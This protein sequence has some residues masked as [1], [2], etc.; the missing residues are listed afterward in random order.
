MESNLVDYKK[1]FK[2][3][4]SIVLKSLINLDIEEKKIINDNDD[5]FNL[6]VFPLKKT[7][8]NTIILKIK[9]HGLISL[10]LLLNS[11]KNEKEKINCEFLSNI[12]TNILKKIENIINEKGGEIINFS[13]NEITIIF[14]FSEA[15]E[16]LEKYTFYYSQL[17][18]LSIIEIYQKINLEVLKGIKLDLSFGVSIGQFSIIFLGGINKKINFLFFGEAIEKANEC[19]NFSNE[20]EIIISKNYNEILT[21]LNLIHS[22]CLYSKG[23]KNLFQIDE[24]EEEEE[25]NNFSSYQHLKKLNL[26]NLNQENIENLTSKIKIISSLFPNNIIEYINLNYENLLSEIYPITIMTMTLIL[27]D[28]NDEKKL[29]LII[30]TIQKIIFLTSGKIFLINKIKEG[31]LIKILFGLNFCSLNDTSNSISSSFLIINSLKKYNIKIA[32]GISSGDNYIGLIN[33]NNYNIIGYKIYLSKKLNEEAIKNLNKN[34][35]ENYILIDKETMKLSQK[36]YRSIYLG[37]IILK[38]NLIENEENENISSNVK[39]YYPIEKEELFIPNF[40]DPFPFI[41]THLNNSFNKK[42]KNFLNDNFKDIINNNDN[43]FINEIKNNKLEDENLI[44]F[45]IKKSQIFFGNYY[46]LNRMKNVLNDTFDKKNKQFIL[47]KGFIGV[48]KS[49]FLRKSLNNFIGLNN[50]LGK[51]YFLNYPFLFCSILNPVNN[52]ISFNCLNFIFRQIFLEIL[53]RGKIKKIEEMCLKNNIKKEQIKEINS[54]LSL[55]KNDINL[56]LLFQKKNKKEEKKEEDIFINIKKRNE[57]IINLFFLNMII[58]YRKILNKKINEINKNLIPPLIFIIEDIQKADEHSLKF[59]NDLY[60][61]E[62]KILLPLII[63]ITYQIPLFNIKSSFLNYKYDF[64]K[65]INY[66]SNDSKPNNLICFHIK[67]LSNYQDLEKLLIFSCQNSVL[68]NNT[69]LERIDEKI[70]AFILQ[71]SFNGIPLFSIYL[72]KS[73][74]NNKFIQILSGEFII[75]NELLDDNKIFDWCD[76]NIPVLYEQLYGE[77]IKNSF[78]N[79]NIL[80]FKFASLIGNLFDIQFLYNII[81]FKNLFPIQFIIEQIKHFENLSFLE[82]YDFKKNENLI[83]QFNFPFFRECFFHRIP[84]YIKTYFNIIFIKKFSEREKYFSE[85][86][87]RKLFVKY[88]NRSD[89]NIYNE[90]EERDLN[91]IIINQI[92]MINL[93]KLKIQSINN[94]LI[95]LKQKKEKIILKNFIEIHENHYLNINEVNIYEDY[96]ELYDTD[97]NKSFRKIFFQNIFSVKMIKND[98]KENILKILFVEENNDLEEKIKIIYLNSQDKIESYKLFIYINY[99]RVINIYENNDLEKNQFFINENIKEKNKLNIEINKEKILNKKE[100]IIPSDFICP[101][102]IIFK[103]SFPIFLGIIL[104]NLSSKLLNNSNCNIIN[105]EKDKNSYLKVPKLIEISINDYIGKNNKNLKRKNSDFN[106]SIDNIT[107]EIIPQE[108]KF[109]INIVSFMELE[110][111]SNIINYSTNTNINKIKKSKKRFLSSEKENI[112]INVPNNFIPKTNSK[113]SLKIKINESNDT[114]ID[115]NSL[116]DYVNKNKENLDLFY[117]EKNKFDDYFYIEN[118]NETNRKIHKSNIFKNLK[119]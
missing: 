12:I 94:I 79:E 88:I 6:S 23:N 81:P 13:D 91:E 53:K 26:F 62:I 112:K 61:K 5:N 92:E 72:I 32:I 3:L 103:S 106:L 67:P 111:I 28:N 84:I 40:Q 113:S 43:E 33:K 69:I 18:L 14:D 90:V 83:C 117:N 71:K 1:L 27:N 77:I 116:K 55:G 36:H 108:N 49:L 119:K 10:S 46:E 98:K 22:F 47:I 31:L 115:L 54:I 105:D 39:I 42:S 74:L 65:N 7:F 96:F 78:S 15:N 38:E 16:K 45:R 2:F 57:N 76:I 11:N 97:E 29:Q 24:F 73:L 107:E 30:I 44:N 85:E 52:L 99:L 50:D 8:E 41:R 110:P 58:I 93:I 20:N 64:L 37:E 60:N 35:I 101:L 95:T 68:K 109:D 118:N 75:T 63:I 100:E 82:I 102:K 21:K 80:L 104:Q 17:V 19:I 56:N 86:T 4:P 70:L 25:L 66:Y 48:G 34:K 9:I 89:I 59:L 114:N 87:E 51:I